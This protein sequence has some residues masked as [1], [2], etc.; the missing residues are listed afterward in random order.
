[1]KA[2]AVSWCHSDEPIEMHPW[3]VGDTNLPTTDFQL[4]YSMLRDLLGV[5]EATV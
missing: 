5:V 4:V 1:V 2:L 3:L